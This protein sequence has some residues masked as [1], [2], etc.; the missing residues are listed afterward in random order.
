MAAFVDVYN[1]YLLNQRESVLNEVNA[2]KKIDNVTRAELLQ[3]LTPM[4]LMDMDE[5]TKKGRSLLDA[6][7]KG[8]DPKF[9][10]RL[11]VQEYY[12]AMLDTPGSRQT[13]VTPLLSNSFKGIA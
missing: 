2:N 10:A 5:R 9:K 7:K 11:G 6:A 13:R 12:A 8:E 4:N 3:L 1:K